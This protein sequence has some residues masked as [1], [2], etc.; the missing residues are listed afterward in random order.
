MTDQPPGWAAPAAPPP[1]LSPSPPD[2][3]G[4]HD[5]AAQR[6][7]KG[8][9]WTLGVLLG[10]VQLAVPVVSVV[11][12]IYIILTTA[13][14]G[15]D[16]EVASAV[17]HDGRV[18]IPQKRSVEEGG[19]KERRWF[20]LGLTL[21][22][23]QRTVTLPEAL[24]SGSQPSLVATGGEL[25]ALSSRKRGKLSGDAVESAP[26]AEQPFAAASRPF[27]LGSGPAV[28]RR[29]DRELT[30]HRLQGG[31]WREAGV[32][33]LELPEGAYPDDIMVLVEKK[34]LHAFWETT[35][36]DVMYGA[37]E[38][39][40]DSASF[41]KITST[42]GGFCAGRVD[43]KLWVARVVDGEDTDRLEL[44]GQGDDGWSR[45]AD[46][47]DTSFRDLHAVERDGQ[48][49]IVAESLLGGIKL[50][51]LQGDDLEVVASVG[52]GMGTILMWVLLPQLG[53]FVLTLLFALVVWLVL[54]GARV[55]D[56]AGAEG[57]GAQLA[58]LLRRSV[59]RL[60]DTAIIGL[61]AVVAL[62]WALTSGERLVQITSTGAQAIFV[63]WCFAMFFALCAWEGHSGLTPGKALAG[64][65]VLG[66]D[67]RPCGFG[68]ALVRNLMLMVDGILNYWVGIMII[69]LSARQQRTGDMMAKTV[70]IRVG[71]RSDA[72]GPMEQVFS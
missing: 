30:V 45:L 39:G 14:S 8:V 69:A 59:A 37:G 6:R 60:V 4:F 63:V 1:P 47:E 52:R 34:R 62:P 50:L 16:V 46:L 35:D 13:F 71:S 24:A 29:D 72:A 10:L 28:L 64:I 15:P 55:T 40:G 25:W 54:R 3:A 44:L 57:G 66:M 58:S 48:T 65:R 53:S 21:K 31:V 22:G 68:R 33:G 7:V 20:L 67:L 38:V 42:D 5:A 9:V 43:G 36:G 12:I 17:W 26:E 23:E 18:W 19:K 32:L 11:W 27:V 51:R 70:V 2:G 56:Y 61:P 49:I 41:K